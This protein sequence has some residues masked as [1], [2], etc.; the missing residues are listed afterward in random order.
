MTSVQDNFNETK[1]LPETNNGPSKHQHK[2]F[3]VCAG[4]FCS[5]DH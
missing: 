1:I 5:I 3:V 4:K 2:N